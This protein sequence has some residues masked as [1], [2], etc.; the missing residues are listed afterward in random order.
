MS[1]QQ[2]LPNP[3]FPSGLSPETPL[4]VDAQQ[5]LPCSIVPGGSQSEQSV[6]EPA[7]SSWQLSCDLT[8]DEQPDASSVSQGVSVLGS[9][10]A[11]VD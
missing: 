4:S 6:H 7:M 1:H 2:V 5:A 9:R 11:H 3:S 8:E 10:M